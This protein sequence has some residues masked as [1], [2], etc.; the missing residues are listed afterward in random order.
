VSAAIVFGGYGTFGG[1]LARELAAAGVTVTVA[2]RHRQRA[3]QAA[4]A[5]GPGHRGLAVDLTD[6]AACRSALRGQAVAVNGAGSLADLGPALLQAC[7]EAACPYVDIAVERAHADL[8]R[9]WSERFR[10]RGLAAVYGCCSLPGISGALALLAR[11]GREEPPRRAR[12][13]LFI[14]NDNP[15]GRE[16][17]LSLLRTLGQSIRAPQGVLRGF[18][19]REVVPLPPPFGRRGVFNFDSPEYDLFPELLGVR[20]V[21]VKVGFEMRPA[22]YGFALLAWTGTRLG[23]R[24]A[25]FVEWAGEW[26]RWLGCSG[27]AV[28][29]ELF[30]GDGSE[31]RC[32]LLARRDG[33]R[34][35]ALPCALAALE[36]CGG[37]GQPTGSLTAYELLGAG[38]LLRAIASRGF[39]LWRD[40]V[41][42]CG[43]T[44]NA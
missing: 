29:A 17:V 13:T 34:M 38:G 28:M 39:E 26:A 44:R 2:G 33:Q 6:P 8:V 20:A 16:A 7:V 10:R 42:E 14:G 3:E 5:L 32:C 25:A 23:A 12:C 31:R 37:A 4:A 24:T 1:H 35:A 40:G 41:L 19:D 21:S 36:L 30:Y 15:K 9:S 27:G 43:T 18:G 22:N 11:A